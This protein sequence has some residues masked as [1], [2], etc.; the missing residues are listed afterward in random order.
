MR[1]RIWHVSCTWHDQAF[2]IHHLHCYFLPPKFD[3]II[4]TLMRVTTLRWNGRKQCPETF[5][6]I[7]ILVYWFK[8]QSLSIWVGKIL[9]KCIRICKSAWIFSESRNLLVN[10]LNLKWIWVNHWI[11]GE[12]VKIPNL[13]RNFFTLRIPHLLQSSLYKKS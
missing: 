2:Q 9:N 3:C 4:Y 6:Y 8:V 11:F 7:R 1:L 12:S 10:L 5:V 13:V